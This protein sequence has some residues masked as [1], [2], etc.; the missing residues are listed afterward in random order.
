MSDRGILLSLIGI[1]GVGKTTI[2]RAVRQEIERGGHPVRMVSWRDQLDTAAG[3]WPR[4]ALQELWLETFRGLYGAATLVGGGTPTLAADY[5]G[6]V[7]E[8]GEDSL[9]GL[10]VTGNRPAGPLMAALVE[11]A[12]NLVLA[13]EVVTPLLEA[14]V[15]VLQE[16]Y[17]LKHVLKECLLAE[18][19]LAGQA[20]GP[21]SLHGLAGSIR[22][23][24][25]ELFDDP[26]VRPDVTLFVDGDARLAHGWRTAQSAR[27]GPLEDFAAT[28]R[29]GRDSYVELQEATAEEYRRL[30]H[31]HG[32]LT[33]VATE[34]E[35]ASVRAALDL[36]RQQAAL[37]PVLGAARPA[38]ER[39][40]R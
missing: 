20:A 1:D 25:F 38:G 5:A 9:S 34:G 22:R 15:T 10:P 2:A 26:A 30:A 12:G 27:V 36:L 14:G 7:R 32:W 37:R 8:A 4:D 39:L 40:P 19:L 24:M 31:R 35:D 13:A 21:R 17:P 28:G 33:H 11:M 3:P 18:E 29:A 23:F 6:W 16:T